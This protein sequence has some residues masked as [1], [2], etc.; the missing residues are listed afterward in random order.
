MM[1]IGSLCRWLALA[2]VVVAIQ[3]PARAD[4][5]KTDKNGLREKAL[6]LN[7]VT[8]DETIKG[9]IKALVDAP[10]AAKKLLAV[11]VPMAK[12]KDQ[13]FNYNGAFILAN[14]AL[15]LKDLE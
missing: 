5:K 4:D 11:A 2:L 10:E 9:E 7:D 13:P 14:A 1:R 8:G 3:S 6:A 12:E 15:V